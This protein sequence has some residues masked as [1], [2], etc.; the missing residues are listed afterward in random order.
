[1]LLQLVGTE[2]E[3]EIL[4]EKEKT[5]LRFLQRGQPPYD[6]ERKLLENHFDRIQA[7]LQ[8]ENPPPYE[9]E[10]QPTSKCNANCKHCFGKDYK[11]TQDKIKTKPAMRRIIDQVLNFK[12]ADFKVDNIKFCGSTG[13]PLLNPLTLYAIDLIN[14]QRFVRLFTNGITIAQNKDNTPYLATVAKID[15]A[16]FSLDAGSTE[17]L[18]KTKPGSR[19]II[20]EDIL[21]GISK[22]R[23]LS[24]KTDMTMSYAITKENYID[25]VVA[26]KKAQRTGLNRIRYRIDLTDRTISTQSQ[27]IIKMLEEAKQYETPYFKVAFIHSNQEIGETNKDHFGSKNC[28]YKCF[29]SRLWSCIGS[30]GE[31]YPC[32]HIVSGDFPSYGSLLQSDFKDIWNSSLKKEISASLPLEKCHLCS[33]FSLRTNELM[34]EI[35]EWP[36]YSLI[37]IQKRFVKQQGL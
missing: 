10:I 30:S 11:R 29:T 8:G 24:D 13:D 27:E 17:I 1:M 3:K 19:N 37:E 21:K 35:S 4:D 15:S 28:G 23:D 22:I 12:E 18:H 9:V 25:I 6:Y 5:F 16:N 34:T 26:A 31:L 33:P 14:Y 20:L 2:E 7:I 32:G 36:L